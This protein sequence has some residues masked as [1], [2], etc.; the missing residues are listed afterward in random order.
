MLSHG[1]E[2][3]DAMSAEDAI[4]SEDEKEVGEDR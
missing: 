3:E 4:P 2:D 1:V